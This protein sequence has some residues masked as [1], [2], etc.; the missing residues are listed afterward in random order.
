M[1]LFSRLRGMSAAL[2]SVTMLTAASLAQA[3][4]VQPIRIGASAATDHAP[5]FAGVEKGIFAKHGLDAKVEMY[6]SGVDMV[7]GLLNGAQDVNVMGSVPY[8][9]GVARGFPLVLIGHLH[10]DPLADN[11]AKNQSVVASS[12]SGVA[13][14]DIAALSGKKIGLPRG[15]GA[16]GY[17]LGVLAAAG[18]TDKDVTLINI[19]PAQLLTALQQGDVDAVAVWEP[20]A[21]TAV[22]KIDGSVRVKQGGCPDCYDPGTVLTSQSVI[23]DKEEVLQ[24]FMVAFAESEQWVRNNFDEAAE[25]NTRWIDGVDLDTMKLAIRASNLD[26][27]ISKYTPEMYQAKAIPFLK[28]LGRV[29]GD[30]DL[31]NAIDLR[32]LEQAETGNP[33][34]FADLPPIPAEL[35][36]K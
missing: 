2:A 3:Q 15:T 35:Q 1:S 25:I 34:F 9:S 6:Q 17:L 23:A 33:E 29:E 27:R 36:M 5:I 4:D 14:G 31:G 20:W 12:A 10:G 24:R 32:F 26:P 7:N 16:E 8:L 28:T 13:E 11:Y 19:Q 18:V 21:S 22:T 30:V